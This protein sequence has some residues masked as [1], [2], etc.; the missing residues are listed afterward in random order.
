MSVNSLSQGFC[1]QGLN[2]R[3]APLRGE[4]TREILVNILDYNE[5]QLKRLYKKGVIE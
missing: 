3:E 1:N 5:T 2:L 4:H